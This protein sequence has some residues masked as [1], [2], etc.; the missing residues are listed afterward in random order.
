[1][2]SDNRVTQSELPRAHGTQ[3]KLRIGLLM[4]STTVPIWVH[5]MLSRIHR[6]DFAT[7]ELIVLNRAAQQETSLAAKLAQQWRDLPLIVLKKA[8]L[9]VYDWAEKRRSG[10]RDAFVPTSCEDLLGD[11][12][13]LE[14]RPRATKFS[15]YLEEEDLQEI[16]GHDIDVFLRLGFNI[17]R[18]GVLEAARHGVW[19]FH[20]GD[21]LVNRGG[22][23][24]FWEIFYRWPGTGSCLQVLSEDL[25]NGLMI[26]RSQ[27]RTDWQSLVRNK[28]GMYWKT[29]SMVPRKLQ[30]LHRD[31]PEIFF[32]RVRAANRHLTLYSNPLFVQPTASR[33]IAFHIRALFYQ[34]T[35]EVRKRFTLDQWILLVS[36]QKNLST[37][38]WRY[39]RITP[40]RDRFWADPFVVKRNG[41]YFVFIEEYVYSDRC[42]TVCCLEIDEKGN[43]KQPYAVLERPY[44]L[45]Y[46]FVFEHDGRTYMLP[47]SAE[48]RTIE[49]Y[50]CENF[51]DKWVLN[52]TM[53]SGI[54]A[55]DST[56]HFH[57]GLWWLFTNIREN[58]GASPDDE[59]FLFF[60]DSPFAENWTPHPLNPIVSDASR[61]RPA[62]KLFYH[63]EMLYRPSQ[64]CLSRYGYGFNLNH[65]EVLTTGDY[66]EERVT[67]VYPNWQS[68]VLAT[69][70]FNFVDGLT[71]SDALVRR[72]KFF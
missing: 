68:D 45:S 50:E 19:S 39:K 60:A 37:S 13:V 56:L 46:P 25:D 24:G 58:E 59:L 10:Y 35:A 41:T 69:H 70:S 15:H 18:G 26:Q 61:A 22:P 6:S 5:E 34:L 42:G 32:Q 53:M 21:H 66:Q 52:K 1:M 67:D 16:A 48:N 33:A 28:C 11:I 65:I 9:A 17:L 29:L 51:P 8:T 27:S 72:F 43:W 2:H 12:P 14:V 55:V 31:G 36:Q 38:L 49:L 30:E 62:G 20:H 44:H 54:Y 47:E 7:I 71:V 57:D 3:K 4:D 64:N 40:P 63:E 23:A